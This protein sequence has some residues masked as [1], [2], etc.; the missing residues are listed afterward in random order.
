MVI[1]V[2]DGW[3]GKS[4]WCSPDR[5][6]FCPSP[7]KLAAVPN[8]YLNGGTPSNGHVIYYCQCPNLGPG[9]TTHPAAASGPLAEV[10]ICD[11]DR[12]AAAGRVKSSINPTGSICPIPLTGIPCPSGQVNVGEQMRGPLRQQ[13]S[14]AMTPNGVCCES[15][16]G[17]RRAERAARLGRSPDLANGTCTPVRDDAV[18]GDER[19]GTTIA[20]ANFEPE[21]AARAPWFAAACR[22]RVAGIFVGSLEGA[23]IAGRRY[24]AG[25]SGRD[26]LLRRAEAASDRAGR[27]PRGLDI[28]RRERTRRSGSSICSTW[29]GRRQRSLSA[30][31][32]RSR[33]RLRRSGRC[34]ASRSTTATPPN[35]YVAA[36]S[37]YGLPIVAPGPDGRLRHIRAGAPERRFHA[38]QWGPR[39]GPGSIWKIDG[40]TARV[41]LFANVTTQRPSQFGRRARR[42]RLRSAVSKSL[43]VA[44]RETGVIH[45]IGM[46]GAD[47]GT[48]D[49]GLTG[50]VNPGAAAS[51]LDRAAAGRCH[52]PTIRQRAIP[53]PGISPRPSG[54][55]SA[56]RSMSAASTS[57]RRQPADLVR[58]P[59]ARTA[60]AATTR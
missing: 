10:C 21:A 51:A 8:A 55:S 53:R 41:S 27:R 28:H 12:I 48:Y 58:R 45:R 59:Q 11:L 9:Q 54:A 44:D 7:M 2:T 42:A 39:G 43:F 23:A 46:D 35:I 36:S 57:G 3:D 16:R 32:S 19:S 40:A 20:I 24:R 14:Q 5:Y 15:G 37:A 26:R 47:R 17:H 60:R 49:H 22:P 34:S 31:R 50:R 18:G 1:D 25:R 38:G 52:K 30:R 29:G 56:S 6:C 4:Y 33:F 13:R